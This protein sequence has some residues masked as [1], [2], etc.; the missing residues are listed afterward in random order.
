M[1]DAP[2]TAVDDTFGSV[3]DSS[4]NDTSM[5]DKDELSVSNFGLT[6]NKDDLPKKET[7]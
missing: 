1:A 5:G 6:G 2:T 3:T 4:A 7:V